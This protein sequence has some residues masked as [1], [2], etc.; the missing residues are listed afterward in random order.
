MN[1]RNQNLAPCTWI[2]VLVHITSDEIRPAT[3]VQTHDRNRTAGVLRNTL[4]ID[5][6]NTNARAIRAI[7]AMT[8]PHLAPKLIVVPS[9]TRL[10]ASSLLKVTYITFQPAPE[11][12]VHR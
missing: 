5:N 1:I 11:M 10:M 9:D 2:N 6:D 8:R 3:G 7:R 12:P 4:T